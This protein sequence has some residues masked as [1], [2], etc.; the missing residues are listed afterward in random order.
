MV[1]DL[2]TTHT[3]FPTNKNHISS[4]QSNNPTTLCQSYNN[5][6]Q[7]VSMAYLHTKPVTAHLQPPDIM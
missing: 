3:N 7:L 2:Y 5:F 4:Q 6:F 1:H